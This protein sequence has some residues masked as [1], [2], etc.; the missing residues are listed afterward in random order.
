MAEES[1]SVHSLGYLFSKWFLGFILY[2]FQFV[3]HVASVW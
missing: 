1:Q 2:W 3:V